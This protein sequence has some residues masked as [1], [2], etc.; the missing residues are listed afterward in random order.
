MALPGILVDIRIWDLQNAKLESYTCIV[1]VCFYFKRKQIAPAHFAVDVTTTRP[2][3]GDTASIVL[4]EKKQQSRCY[5][6]WG[7]TP[8]MAVMFQGEKYHF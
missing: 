2:S 3:P 6:R 5:L 1:T 4:G 7:R 8:D